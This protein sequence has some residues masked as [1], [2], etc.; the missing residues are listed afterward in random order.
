MPDI[1]FMF[2]G[3]PPAAALWF[4][5]VKQRLRRRLWHPAVLLHPDSRGEVLLRSADPAR[6]VRIVTNFFSAPN[7]LP[8]LRQ[9]F[10][11]AREVAAQ[12]P[13][14]RFRGA[15]DLAG[16]NVKT[17]AEIEEWIR[18]TA[19]TATIRPRPA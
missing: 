11:I 14:A 3:A 15:R 6:P 2:R 4:P 12:Q 9:G 5:G 8:T 13:L 16:P 1:E 10:K 7:D 17:D 19:A 18:N